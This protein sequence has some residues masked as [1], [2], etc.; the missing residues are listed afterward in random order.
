NA[1]IYGFIA[2]HSP[3]YNHA[4]PQLLMNGRRLHIHANSSLTSFKYEK[5]ISSSN[6]GWLC[7]PDWPQ[8]QTPISF[9]LPNAGAKESNTWKYL[10]CPFLCMKYQ[11]LVRL[12]IYM[13]YYIDRLSYV[14]PSL[15]LWDKAYLVMVDN[16]FDVF[17]ELWF[18]YY[19]EVDLFFFG[20]SLFGVLSL[21][22]FFISSL[23]AS[24][25]FLKSFLVMN[26]SASSAL[27][28]ISSLNNPSADL[29]SSDCRL[30]SLPPNGSLLNRLIR[31]ASELL[32][33]PHDWQLGLGPASGRIIRILIKD[34][35]LVMAR[36]AGQGKEEE[37]SRA[38]QQE[39]KTPDRHEGGH[40]VAE[41]DKAAGCGPCGNLNINRN[42]LT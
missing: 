42:G 35:D 9:G 40:H 27:V 33:F 34:T 25:S 2:T 37:E 28:K 6:S 8:T 12:F 31:R 22:G 7:G 16:V 17:L 26:S 29:D 4:F 19:V 1:H 3:S 39:E 30:L 24:I 32:G 18:D 15:H 23:R 41:Q 14:E 5:R 10:M 36:K 20:S 21:K 38:R 13:V 11:Y